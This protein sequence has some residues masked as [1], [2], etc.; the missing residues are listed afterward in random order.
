MSDASLPDN[1]EL[2][3]DD[4]ATSGWKEKLGDAAIDHC[5]KA[6][7]ELRMASEKAQEDGDLLGAKVL[8][9]L[10]GACSM[11]LTNKSRSEPFV[12]M[13]V[14]DGRT[15]PTPDWFG[16]DDIN[17][18]LHVLEEVDHPMFKGRLADI[19]WIK[20]AQ[21]GVR[22]AREAIDSYRSLE[23]TE[24]TWGT[25]IGD[26]WKR[27][28]VLTLMIGDGA[29]DR[30]R[31]LETALITKLDSAIK[32][33]GFFAH[34]LAE[35]LREF[36][37]GKGLEENIAKQMSDL[38]RGFEN[39]GNFYS[40]RAYYSLAGDWFS[41][42][43]QREKQI[44][45][46]VAEA[47]GWAK[48]AEQRTSSDN[49]SALAAVEFYE[50]AI[51]AYREI[52]RAERG[53]RGIDERI[54]ELM[55]L[56]EDAG[57]MALGEMK[58][59]GTSAVDIGE[60]VQH[61]KN[62]V[63]GKEP[64]EAL[65]SFACL[66]QTKAK[67]LRE[68][69]QK[70]IEE[71]PLIAL[72][73]TTTLS[74]DGRVAAKSPGMTPT[75]KAEASE[76]AIWAQMIRNYHIESELAVRGCILPAL[77]VMHI[78]HRF[79]EVDFITLSKNSPMVPPGRE[80][81][82]GKALFHGYEYDFATALHLLTPQ[83]EHMVRYRLKAIGVNTIVTDGGIQDE[84]GLGSLVEAPEFEQVFG[85]DL[86]FEIRSLF[87]DHLGA[88]LRNNVSHGLLTYQECQSIDSVYGWWLGLKIVFRTYWAEYQRYVAAGSATEE[89][90][91]ESDES[92]TD[93][94]V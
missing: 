8:H 66:H 21:G 29:G 81:L 83:I 43:D 59:I 9:L 24:E 20:K 58:T 39:D 4:F 27:A 62:E 53:S 65:N 72:V 11:R 70:N 46:Q 78:E 40:A 16:E 56:H 13:W 48:E 18:L 12:P 6:F 3:R 14:V 51:Q 38:G 52:P 90:P 63:T 15:T 77:Q 45:M 92:S 85:E 88:N 22:F 73:S 41:N 76:P 35:N 28:L 50:N 17:L 79:R 55:R 54:A 44:D 91:Q 86:A 61:S 5:A 2:S 26:C 80:E 89:Y 60:I 36:G 47:E 87:C 49:P 37:L 69:A 1:P 23:L 94:T 30:I 75:G 42:A 34:W 25:E 74:H 19:L 33:D 10:A 93:S 64:I 67:R 68:I 32:A 31:E 84:K 7:D 57:A 71:F 82:F